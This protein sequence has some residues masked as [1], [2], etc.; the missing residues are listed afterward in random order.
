MK[1]NFGRISLLIPSSIFAMLLIIIVFSSII[2]YQVDVLWSYTESLYNH[3]LHV[4]QVTRNIKIETLKIQNNIHHLTHENLTET[5]FFEA[6]KE[7]KNSNKVINQQFQI[8]YLRYLGDRGTI[9]NAYYD[10][11][12]WYTDIEKTLFTYTYKDK[13]KVKAALE[14]LKNI[15][16]KDL[17]SLNIMI[18]FANRK[19]IELF[20]S[21]KTQKMELFK[22]STIILSIAVIVGFILSVQ[23]LKK[24]KV[25]LNQI[26]TIANEYNKGNYLVRWNY[27]KNDEFGVL[28]ESFNDMTSKLSVDLIVKEDSVEIAKILFNEKNIE[29]FSSELLKVLLIKTNGISGVI[30]L[31]DEKSEC[32]YPLKSVGLLNENLKTFSAKNNEGEIGLVLLN[33]HIT[34]IN[35]I[36]S[37]TM[38]VFLGTVGQIFPKEIILIPVLNLNKVIGVISIALIEVADLRVKKLLENVYHFINARMNSVLLFEQNIKYTEELNKY[39]LELVD[40]SNVLSVQTQRL[41]EFNRELE[42]Q[43]QRLV[44]ANQIKNT[45]LSNMTHELRTP[46]NSIISLSGLLFRKNKNNIS[47]EEAEYLNIIERNG[48]HLLGIINDILELSRIEAGKEEANY[49][50]TSIDELITNVYKTLLPIAKEK[51][52]EIIYNNNSGLTEIIT[53]I[54]K[55]K[56]VLQN[57]IGNAV[58]FTE[59]GI[60]EIIIEADSTKIFIK[61]KDTGIGIAEDQIQYIFDEFK[62]G[63]TNI[64][65]KYGGTGLGLAIADKYSKV[66]NGGIEVNSKLGV[67]SEFMIWFPII[68]KLNAKGEISTPIIHI[69][70]LCEKKKIMII[71]D[72]EIISAQIENMF[73]ADNVQLIWANDSHKIYNIME[74]SKPNVIILDMTN[75][76]ID[77]FAIL[78]EIKKK[79]SKDKI[80]VVVLVSETMT[81]LEME[82]IH[83]NNICR[84]FKNKAFDSGGLFNL[85]KNI[86]N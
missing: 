60:I 72:S 51:G 70:R 77:G 20:D 10:Y 18:E 85:L 61:V 45:F 68:Q 29:G 35:N 64:A 5:E 56:H 30:Y 24:I 50:L 80:P 76:G 25:P 66:L 54:D 55:I 27:D 46:L 12:S 47:E 65:K 34:Y 8:L 78:S 7:I 69:N 43:K 17:E 57:V 37:D 44:K 59:K 38:F 31:L 79:D 22:N 21:A 32:Y 1:I 49:S 3:P 48:K 6:I 2:Y 62:Q 36:P 86:L 39:N 41:E 9:H 33:K 84:I 73:G 82:N 42:I 67:G 16:N 28:A 53:D 81:D 71:E 4:S 58:K 83:G 19:A 14:S 74:L 23:L 15:H 11:M 63:D 75:K 40:K 13:A 26:M 52:L